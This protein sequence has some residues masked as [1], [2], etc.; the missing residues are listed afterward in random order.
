VNRLA[1]AR[2]LLVSFA[3]VGCASTADPGVAQPGTVAF[4]VAAGTIVRAEDAVTPG[5]CGEGAAQVFR[6]VAVLSRGNQAT[7]PQATVLFGGSFPCF[8][9][10]LFTNLPGEGAY[11]IE[12]FGYDKTTWDAR[13]AELESLARAQASA[14]TTSAE[15]RKRAPR[16]HAVCDANVRATT[17]VIATCSAAPL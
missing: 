4:Q 11:S 12:L 3:I 14:E 5:V 16:S 8:A 7:S 10:A 15:L 13:A 6:Y 9:D 2:S 1:L 17:Q